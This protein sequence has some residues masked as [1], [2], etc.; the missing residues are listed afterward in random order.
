MGDE[1][2][3]LSVVPTLVGG[4]I[5]LVT[6]LSMFGLAQYIERRKRANERE[7]EGGAAA[8]MGFWKLK[9][10]AE[11]LVNLQRE[12]GDAFSKASEKGLSGA[13]PCQIVRGMVGAPALIE[14]L[15][16]KELMFLS[17]EKRSDLIAEADLVVHRARNIDASMR[18]YTE[19]R[20]SLQVFLEINSDR[21]GA[22]V[23]AVSDFALSGKN[24]AIA[25]LKIDSLNEMLEQ[26]GG[27]LKNDAVAAKKVAL[28]YLGVAKKHFG[29]GFPSFQFDWVEN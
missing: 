23:G 3:W 14:F 25:K 28:E 13:E 11:M 20:E 8:F 6:S 9:T 10:T 4:G 27:M 12:I 18:K 22:S 26:I 5:S 17:K 29:T 21:V 15:E 16:A 2:K 24:A 19:L 7:R 1:F